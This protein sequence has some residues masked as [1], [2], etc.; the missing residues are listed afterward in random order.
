MNGP[1][2]PVSLDSRSLRFRIILPHPVPALSVGRSPMPSCDLNDPRDS[3]SRR[4]SARWSGRG[5]MTLPETLVVV[6][7]TVVI[8]A[9]LVPILTR[10]RAASREVAC[11]GNLRQLGNGLPVLRAGR[12]PPPLPGLHADPLG[13]V[14]RQVPV[15]ADLP[16]R[17]GRGTRAGH[18]QQLRL[19]R[20]RRAPRRPSRARRGARRSDRTRSWRSR[21]CPAGTS[22]ADSTSPAWTARRKRWASDEMGAELDRPVSGAAAR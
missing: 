5:G 15:V 7:I 4:R 19:A 2:P 14:A 20:H 12:G 10:A 8:V 13:A 9:L 1:G 17:V 21:P 22:R 11:I 18:R 3:A 16:L 6:G